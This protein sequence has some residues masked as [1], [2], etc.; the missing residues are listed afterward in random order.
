MIAHFFYCLNLCKRYSLLKYIYV[1]LYFL[2]NMDVCNHCFQRDYH[3]FSRFY[4]VFTK[5][6]VITEA[7]D[8]QSDNQ[9]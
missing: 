4:N 8:Y 7:S 6:M 3:V 9:F 5:T 2:K 1:K